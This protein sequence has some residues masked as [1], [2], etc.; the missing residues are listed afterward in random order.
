MSLKECE[1]L[2]KK[3]LDEGL[4]PSKVRKFLLASNFSEK[5]VD[6]A[7]HK[8]NRPELAKSKSKAFDFLYDNFYIIFFAF[9]AGV[10]TYVLLKTPS[11]QELL[12]PFSIVILPKII[13]Y[14]LI[15]K[16]TADLAFPTTEFN[17]S[18]R[19]N[20]VMGTLIG[21]LSPFLS[22][23]LFFN[24][25]I[26]IPILLFII[27]LL[28]GLYPFKLIYSIVMLVI[29][30]GV[31]MIFDAVLFFLLDSLKSDLTLENFIK[32]LNQTMNTSQ[33]VNETV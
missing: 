8:I 7:L 32:L 25:M 30:F 1:D 15:I 14:T 2:A 11:F 28:K 21:I 12:I 10:L 17:N 19:K 20:I 18:W 29:L 9:L 13:I 26:S 33:F 23:N 31:T 3:S 5:E 27:S 6:K 22:F 16:I 24:W 4:H